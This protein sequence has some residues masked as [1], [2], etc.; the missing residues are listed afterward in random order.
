MIKPNRGAYIK[1]VDKFQ[2]TFKDNNKQ[3]LLCSLIE[4]ILTIQM[5][6]KFY[7]FLGQCFNGW[8]CLSIGSKNND[9]KINFT[10]DKY[11]YRKISLI[12][13]YLKKLIL[14]F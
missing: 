9:F 14:N 4:K 5:F 1:N 10:N 13:E 7:I 6:N 3:Y 8:N 11:D 2:I 12:T